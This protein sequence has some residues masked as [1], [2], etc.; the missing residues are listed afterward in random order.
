MRTFLTAQF[1]ILPPS[2]NEIY[3]TVTLKDG[4][5]RRVL[6]KA[7]RE[8]RE[9]AFE[10]LAYL[11]QRDHACLDLVRRTQPCLDMRLFVKI[12]QSRIE[13][14]DSDDFIKLVQDTVMKWIGYDDSRVYD[15]HASKRP[16]VEG[17]AAFLRVTVAVLDSEELANGITRTWAK[18]ATKK[19][20]RSGRRE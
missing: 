16:L 11:S 14:R 5:Q 1:D 4:R 13:R 17:E 10:T 15:I 9:Y 20:S 19:V 2:A 18:P 3:P 6:S 8:W 7:A 12:P